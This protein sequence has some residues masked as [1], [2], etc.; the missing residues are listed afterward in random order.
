M[1]DHYLRDCYN[2]RTPAR[3]DDFAR[4]LELTPQYLARVTWEA[5]GMSPRDFLRVR[6]LRYA[7]HLLVTTSLS[8]IEI[9]VLSGFGTPPTFYRA[10]KAAYGLTPGAYRKR[11]TK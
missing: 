9:A 5:F 2:R 11:L 7:E 10:F 8:T 6:Q 4:H 3:S 1:G